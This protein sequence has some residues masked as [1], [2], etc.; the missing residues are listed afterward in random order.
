MRGFK[1]V[2]VIRSDLRMSVGKTAAQASHAAVL[3]LE[4]ARRRKPEWVRE[5]F[6]RGQKKVVLKVGSE[7]ELRRVASAC[8]VRGLPFEIVED[9][10]LTELPPGTATAVGIGPA[11]EEEIDKVTGSL[12]LL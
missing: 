2:L 4:A 12:P 8:A 7:E 1:Q 10:G 9:A 3:A 6:D 11:P 5:W